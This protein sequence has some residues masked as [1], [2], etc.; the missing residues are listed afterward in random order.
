MA[1]SRDQWIQRMNSV[2]NPNELAEMSWELNEMEEFPGKNELQSMITDRLRKV[3]GEHNS[4][5]KNNSLMPVEF[6]SASELVVRPEMDLETAKSLWETF[7][8]F[9][10]FILQDPECYDKI[11]DSREM[12]RTGA[13]RLAVPFGLSIEERMTEETK[14]GD[15]VRFV[16]HLRVSKGKRHVDCIGSCRVSE[17]PDSSKTTHSQREHFAYTKAW[18]R[19]AKRGIADIL[20][21]TEAE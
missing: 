15:D 21:G 7:K 17:I 19:A 13:T 1:T 10:S 16:V 20:G 4:T 5:P 6:V 11:G 9:K 3:Q 18:T 8:E 12:N 14:M 2:S